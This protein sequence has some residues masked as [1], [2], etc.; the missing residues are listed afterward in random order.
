M[1]KVD[2]LNGVSNGE[3]DDG[4]REAG[5]EKLSFTPEQQEK[6][7]GLIDDAYRKAFSKAQKSSGKI[8]EIERLESEVVRL[9]ED[10]QRAVLYKSISKYN[11]VDAEEVAKLVG[12]NIAMDSGGNS[13][14]VNS[15]GGIMTGD[16]GNSVGVDEFIEGWL[17]ERPHH[18][19]SSVVT[20]AGSRSS[21]YR[22]ESF[23]VNLSD[24][25]AWRT[26][27]RTDLDR[28][29]KEG[30]SIPGSSGQIYKFRDVKNPF[31]EARKRKFKA[32][33]D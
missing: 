27:S 5:R 11:V 25:A 18:L 10:K 6:V 1:E 15:S 24:P 14:V 28:Y 23:N 2:E 22:S 8:G 21:G 9:R 16:S 32:G 4:R 13:V 30:I 33:G 31:L 20:G 7:Q 29:L 26:M 19:R 12:E 17:K 3:Y